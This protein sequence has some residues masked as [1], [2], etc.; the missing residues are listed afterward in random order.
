MDPAQI[1]WQGCWW[2]PWLGAIYQHQLLARGLGIS[3][4]GWTMGTM[5]W[6]VGLA[7]SLTVAIIAQGHL[8]GVEGFQ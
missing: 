4:Q 5:W 7:L 8:Q 1:P 2:W 6:S 3:W